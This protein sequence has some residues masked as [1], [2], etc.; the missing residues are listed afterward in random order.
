MGIVS[1]LLKKRRSQNQT[2]DDA[3]P[4]AIANDAQVKAGTPKVINTHDG[5]QDTK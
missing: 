5:N 2:F 1:R 3:D 4:D